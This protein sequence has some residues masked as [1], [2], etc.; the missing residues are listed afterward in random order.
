MIRPWHG[1]TGQVKNES[2]CNDIEVCDGVQRARGAMRCIDFDLSEAL[3]VRNWRTV[4]HYKSEWEKISKMYIS[5][6]N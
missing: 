2:K 1:T 4:A 6:N 3:E 5:R